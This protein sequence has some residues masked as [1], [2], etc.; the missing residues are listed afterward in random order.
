MNRKIYIVAI[1]L[2]LLS[3]GVKAQ[4][5]VK[6]TYDP[7][8]NRVMRKVIVT[9]PTCPAS[10]RIEKKDTTEQQQQTNYTVGVFPNP[11]QDKVNVNVVNSKTTDT[12]DIQLSDENGKILLAAK[13]QPTTNLVDIS[14]YRPGIYYLKVSVGKDAPL[15]Y[16]I[17]KVQ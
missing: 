6:Y 9:C 4:P 13:N 10:G 16:K 1:T 7:S 5:A 15:V 2:I 11:A 3:L 12:I 8:G 14:N 17:L